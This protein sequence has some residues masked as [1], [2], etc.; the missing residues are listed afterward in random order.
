MSHGIL[1]TVVDGQRVRYPLVA[2]PV[3]V[4]YEPDR[5]LITV[6]PQGPSRLQT[7]ALA[8]LD[9]RYLKQLLALAGPA[10]TL[11]ADLWDDLERRELFERALGRLGYD[12]V[13]VRPGDVVWTDGGVEHW[14]GAT[15]TN[16]VTQV[17]L[18]FEDVEWT[19][20][21]TDEEYSDS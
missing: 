16:L 3:I 15:A 11:E 4:E 13:V 12:R 19:G 10:G 20:E 7:D 1:D 9:E 18:H 21:V 14:H 17:I 8:G 2:T 6:S 5:S